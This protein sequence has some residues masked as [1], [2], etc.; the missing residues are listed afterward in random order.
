MPLAQLQIEEVADVLRK[1]IRFKLTTY[2]PEPNNMPFHTRLLGMDR[3]AL[4]SFIHSLSTNFGTAIFEHVAAALARPVYKNVQTQA[5]A[6]DTISAQ[7]QIEI[8]RIMNEL[9]TGTSDPNKTEEVERLRQVCRIG[10]M[11]KVSLTLVDVL[12]ESHAGESY[13]FDIKTAKPNKSGFQG[14]KRMLLEWT[15]AR[16]AANPDANVTAAIAIPY[17]PYEPKP[18]SRWTMKGMLDVKQNSQLFVAQEFWNFI[19]GA[20][21]YDQLLNIFEQIGIELRPEIDARFAQFK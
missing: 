21:A 7:A 15:A 5:I 8:Q 16:L 12:V 1:S 3:L 14:Y 9:T 19:G 13:L 17:N 4:Y 2:N 6:G 18:Y 10:E 11:V 20:G